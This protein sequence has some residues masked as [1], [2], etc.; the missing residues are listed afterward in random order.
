MVLTVFAPAPRARAGAGAC[1]R[2][3]PKDHATLLG[4]RVLAFGWLC[5]CALTLGCRGDGPHA[6]D[7]TASEGAETS[8]GSE[9]SVGGETD[10]AAPVECGSED[11]Q[12]LV[13][14]VDAD[15]LVDDVSFIADIRTPGSTH[16]LAVQELCADRLGELGFEVELHE[17]ETGTNVIGRRAGVSRPDEVVMLSAHYDHIPGCEGANDNATG[18]AGIL[19]A[20]RVLSTAQHA[21]TLAIACWDEE[22][23]GLIGS[24][25]YAQDASAAGEQIVVVYNYDMIGFATDEPGTQ[26]IPTG[27]DLVFPEQY[28]QV[29]DNG[30]RGDFIVVVSDDLAWGPATAIEAYAA[31]VDLPTVWAELDAHSKNHD[32]FADLRRSDHAS[33]WAVD[34]PAIFLTDSG[35]FRS[36]TYHCFGSPDVIDTLDFDF[37]RRVVAATVGSAAETLELQ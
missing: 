27:F 26:E 15:N 11:A 28:A 6:S 35:E 13:A 32:L 14:C 22:E 33:F 23:W 10:T 25:A 19:E 30:F 5:A 24:A 9:T 31:T 12:S 4:M 18:V 8:L 1:R 36:D 20:A 34:M 37:A 29:E 17:Y 21:R 3:W 16:W 7:G 2:R